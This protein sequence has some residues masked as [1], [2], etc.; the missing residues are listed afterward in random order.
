MGQLRAGEHKDGYDFSSFSKLIMVS[1]L[2][3]DPSGIL[4]GIG[5]IP[6]PRVGVPPGSFLKG[7][8][9]GLGLV[10]QSVAMSSPSSPRSLV[11]GC[12]R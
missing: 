4:L 3:F 11:S 2:D 1:T 6:Q 12:E 9:S 5:S 8:T 10:P 7:F